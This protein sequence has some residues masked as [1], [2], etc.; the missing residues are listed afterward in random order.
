MLVTVRKPAIRRFANQSLSQSATRTQHLPFQ[1]A[2][3]LGIS[4]A[5]QSASGI[6]GREDDADALKGG[7]ELL[8]WKA[9][10]VA[11]ELAHDVHLDRYRKKKKKF[12]LISA[13][14]SREGAHRY[15]GDPHLA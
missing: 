9:G 5:E 3:K 14:A 12:Q 8:E 13:F 4:D 1:Q 2:D 6:E 15:C 7:A 11:K 10:R